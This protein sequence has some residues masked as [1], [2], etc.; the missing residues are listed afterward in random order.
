MCFRM[1]LILYVC[2]VCREVIYH[3]FV[4]AWN[5][6]SRELDMCHNQ[7][8]SNSSNYRNRASV[9]YY[10]EHEPNPHLKG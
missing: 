6:V 7:P 8:H 3:I 1:K 5:S 9:T 4:S 2:S 10:Q